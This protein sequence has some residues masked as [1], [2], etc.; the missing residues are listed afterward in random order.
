M[1]DK[2][3][4]TKGG[5]KRLLHL[6]EIETQTQ[7]AWKAAKV[8]ESKAEE[9]W[10]DKYDFE[11]KNRRKFMV[12][13]PYPYMNGKLHLGHAFSFS[14][15][16]FQ[17][18]F[19]RLTGK[20]VLFP[21][22]FHCT[23]MPI[24]AAAKRVAKEL[25]E[26]PDVLAE[27]KSKAE[28]KK[29]KKAAAP[30]KQVEIL[31][32][33]DVPC[34]L[35]PRFADPLFW[36]EYFPPR[37]K[38][39]LESFGLSCDFS[40]SFITTERQ[41][42]Y[43]RFIQWHMLKL[44]EKDYVRFGKRNAI[45][46]ISDNQPCADHDRSEGEGLGPQ[47]YTLIK[48][49]LLDSERV[50]GKL[51]ELLRNNRRVYFVAAT[52]RPETMYGQTNC[53]I[54]PNGDYGLY[55]MSNDDVFLSSE[56]A[57]LNMAY[58]D[59]TKVPKS[60]APLFKV[61]G[62]DIIGVKLSAPL[63]VY[64]EVHLLPMETISMSKGTGVVTSVPSDSPDD[65][66][67]LLSFKN[68]KK[69]REKWNVTD[70]M[71]KE[72]VHIIKLEGFGDLAAKDAVEKFKIK[73]P[74]DKAKL[75]QAKEEV[76]TQGFYKGVLDVGAYKG[77]SIK[78]AKE[79]VKND[80]VKSGD[81][82][83][84]YEPEGLIKNRQNEECVVALVDQ[85]YITYGEEKWKEF[86]TSYVKSG[87]FNAFSESTQ[88]GFEQVLS[89]LS[90]WGLSRTFG[91]GSHIPWDKQYLIES[92]SDST[93]YMAYYTISNFLHADIFGKVAK[94]GVNPE[95]LTEEVFDYIFLGKPIDFTKTKIAKDVLEQMRNSF[96]YWYPMDL[97]CSGKD[98][99]GNH[100]TMSLYN[101]AAVW[102]MDADYMTRAYFCNGYIMVNNEKMSKS[103]G[104]F[105][106]LHE[107]IE[108][109]G[110][111]ASRIA[112]ADCGDTLDD[113]NFVTETCDLSVNKL[114][115]LENFTKILVHE[116]WYK[117]DDFKIEDIN[118]VRLETPS[119]KVFENNMNYLIGAARKA[120]E[121]MKYKN[122]LKYAFYEMINSRDEYILFNAGEKGED[123]G[124]LNP[125]LMVKFLRSF[126]IMI[127]PVVPHW[128]D[129]MY[130]T[131]LNPIFERSNL[132]KYMVTFLVDA[133][134][135]EPSGAVDKR[136]FDYNNYVNRVIAGIRDATKAK[137]KGKKEK[138]DEC[139]VRVMYVREY[140][141]AQKFALGV[142]RA[143]KYDENFKIASVDEKGAPL[144]K[145]RIMKEGE[146][147]PK[148]RSALVEFAAFKA[149]EVEAYGLDA[150]K[151][152]M[153]FNEE[154]V[155]NDNLE[156]FKKLTKNEG[157]RDIE[158]V[159]YSE[160]L[161]PKGNKDTAMPGRPLI[162]PVFEDEK[163]GD[164]KDNKKCDKKD[165]KKCNKSEEEGEFVFL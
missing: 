36:L 1:K 75:Q 71:L 49:R 161:K 136:L 2:S 83:T 20:N 15:C 97:R 132:R 7:A 78:D 63:S 79:K 123:Y 157:I 29:E 56:H 24:A 130:K 152:E 22:G 100:L 150:L 98:L 77:Q 34:E 134:F 124:K 156:L 10:K 113:A 106:T 158:V 91:L 116:T 109:Y 59:M 18:R 60:A 58:Q 154:E 125:T 43:D 28:L 4:D 40:R 159:L 142:L 137:G 66:I 32:D 135:P 14:K 82:L 94:N 148:A 45:F 122:V 55:E 99:I 73:D 31:R 44:K 151:E 12:T 41:P 51:K 53:Y 164:K 149:K 103:K 68:N 69:L 64:K 117:N 133:R 147:D 74:K 143:M 35:I 102:N 89:W 38:E 128:A 50:P 17:A 121:E 141:R 52:L 46:S 72:P 5:S 107:L 86:V 30:P 81:A 95:H 139:T 61:K 127:S 48:M 119:D 92:L 90:F 19:Q 84:Y 47:E 6:R 93:I 88:K 114:Y 39:D 67:N 87:K 163:K 153:L 160:E 115:S 104:N 3:K 131:Y 162:V 146:G 25:R 140:T 144:F 165:S 118:S 54:L 16:E 37:G 105:L 33:L 111:D 11:A 108:R 76:Y 80:L 85:W 23:G 21:F 138:K 101:H 9:N 27:L 120:Y 26:N 70:E 112:L 145:N 13:F 8:F 155:L 129:Y 126:F 62:K 65:Y 96:T 57:I 110:C 42:Y